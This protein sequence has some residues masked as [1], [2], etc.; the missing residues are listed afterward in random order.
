MV[1][2]IKNQ[3]LKHLSRFT[4]NL[5]VDK[6][7][8]STLRGE[9][10]LTNLE[11]DESV[12][13]DLLELPSWL[14]ITSAWCN[15][16][17]IRVQWTKLKSVPICLNLDEVIVEVVTC[18]DL[19]NPSSNDASSSSLPG[20]TKYSFI[21]KV[22]DGITVNVNTAVVTFKSH[23]FIASVQISRI[24]LESKSPTWQRADLRMT[25]VK[26]TD[27]GQLLIFKELEWQTVRI[28]ARSTEDTELTP[29]R[30]LTNQARCRITIKKRLSDCF[31]MGSRLILILDDLLWVLTDSQLKAA[32][33][34]VD[35]LTG[36]IEKATLLERKIKAA[37]KIEVLPEYQAQISQQGRDKIECLTP[38]SKIFMRYDVVETSYHF[39]SQR[40]DLHLCD[41]PGSGRSS[42]P[43]LTNGGALQISLVKFQIDYY[44]Y[45]LALADRKHWAKY[46]ENSTPHAEWLRQSYN[47]FRNQFMD[48][49]DEFKITSSS[50]QNTYHQSN[51]EQSQWCEKRKSSYPLLADGGK[52]NSSSNDFKNLAIEQLSTLMT[53]CIIIRIHDFTIYKVTT[54]TRKPKTKEF[55]AGDREKL[56]LPEDV[57]IVHSEFT[58]YYI[59]G[60]I[61]FPL[62]PPKFYI[63]VNPVKINYDVY[64]CLW[65]NSFVLNLYKSLLTN[66]TNNNTTNSLAYFDVKLEAILPRIIF[67]T[68]IDYQ[69][70]RDRPKSMH[71]QTSRV[72]ITNVRTC[73]KSSR[74]NLAECLNAF[75]MGQMFYTT[76]FPSTANDYNVITE[77]LINHS[78]GTDGVRDCQDDDDNPSTM[79]DLISQL[80][81]KLL[82]TDSKDVWCCNFEPVWADFY[83][84]HSIGINRPLCFLDPF[85]VT[86]WLHTA[87]NTS[88][89]KAEDIHAIAYIKNLVSVQIDHYQL[90]FLL[91]ELEKISEMSTFLI[92]DSNKILNT[93]SGAFIFGGLL[94]QIEVTLIIP[95][96]TVDNLESIDTSSIT[97]EAVN[98][99]DKQ[100]TIVELEFEPKQFTFDKV[101]TPQYEA[102]SMTNIQPIEE[103]VINLKCE[104]QKEPS[105]E[106]LQTKINH[107]NSDEFDLLNKNIKIKNKTDNTP[108]TNNFNAGISSMK[109]GFA[110][111]ITS[112]DSALNPLPED[113]S[114]DTVS[115]RSDLSSD[116]ENY[117]VVT[118]EDDNIDT[119]F[120]GINTTGITPV[121]Q[122]SEV[123]EEFIETH[124]DK[125]ID[126]SCKK[127]DISSAIKFE[128]FKIQVVQQSLGFSTAIK[129]QLDKIDCKESSSIPWN[130]IQKKF[131]SRSKGWS[132][133]QQSNVDCNTCVKIRLTRDIKSGVQIE[134]IKNAKKKSDANS[135]MALFDNNLKAKIDDV[136][137]TMSMSSL[138]GLIDLVEDEVIPDPLPMEI[139]IENTKIKLNEDRPC[140][141]ITSPGPVPIN[142]DISNLNVSRNESGIFQLNAADKF[143]NLRNNIDKNCSSYET[144]IELI[145]LRK[146]TCQL[147]TNN[148]EL[149]RRLCALEN[150]SKENN[151]LKRNQDEFDNVKLKLTSAQNLIAELLKE[152]QVLQETTAVLQQQLNKTNANSG[153]SSWS[154]KR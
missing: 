75:Q 130:E 116:S 37:R 135:L 88:S 124:N 152:K 81:R 50:K 115:M 54:S 10:E 125:S 56:C 38:I 148:N 151:K 41:D 106:F 51:H 8:I 100:K 26:D 85:P 23:T 59:P 55:I 121:E 108:M 16:V 74:A 131:T 140:T 61:S 47:L 80:K 110:N 126:S 44:P 6:I 83:G 147:Q 97:D 57:M 45:H 82:W 114:S 154:M 133:K 127:N 136:N 73:D 62:P 122:A 141:N 149:T 90:L 20:T 103:P 99:N 77:K 25:K 101:L 71:I 49:I 67:E 48:H 46:K 153:R 28:E 150:L 87:T 79:N 117:V 94:S 76:E 95:S 18:D 96:Q 27:R 17:T 14:K 98:K 53:T 84:I 69:N 65:L 146:L 139:F 137:L 63:Q 9:G 24:I 72:S 66:S 4:K 36:L 2:I 86:L 34:F 32:L 7:N 123:I 35:S 107:S 31:V 12:L 93:E 3:L 92:V 144:E 104:T 112:I 22:I 39:F 78:S 145:N 134:D 89:N 91:R 40:I 58:Y 64:S 142:L 33:Y 1:S 52:N 15:K 120:T 119:T 128:L 21:H 105:I 29:L 42:H 68:Q 43:E 118:F 143:D 102:S 30:L 113:G 11:L 109:K 19:R 70:Q 111:F 129:V 132:E 138:I 5:S 13:T 60:Q